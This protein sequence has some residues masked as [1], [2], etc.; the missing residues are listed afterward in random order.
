MRSP[1]PFK[2]KGGH[3]WVYK[4]KWAHT[5]TGKAFL[6]FYFITGGLCGLLW[7]R[8]A[9]RIWKWLG[10]YHITIF[11]MDPWAENWSLD[12]QDGA[13]VHR[14][15]DA[16]YQA[17]APSRQINPNAKAQT[18]SKLST[19]DQ[20]KNAPGA[21]KVSGFG[22]TS[23]KTYMAVTSDRLLIRR[24]NPQGCCGDIHNEWEDVFVQDVVGMEQT[25]TL[26]YPTWY[27]WVWWMP[28]WGLFG[29]HRA[30]LGQKPGCALW[31][32]QFTLGYFGIGWLLDSCTMCCC[33]A[34]LRTKAELRIALRS[35]DADFGVKLRK[36][37]DGDTFRGAI[38]T[39]L[40]RNPRVSPDRAKHE[41]R[42]VQMDCAFE[43]FKRCEKF[44]ENVTAVDRIAV[45][46]TRIT[47]SKRKRAIIPC[48]PCCPICWLP[49]IRCCVPK[50]RTVD[51]E[52]QEVCHGQGTKSTSVFYESNSDI[53]SMLKIWALT[54]L[55]GGHFFKARWNKMALKRVSMWVALIGIVGFWA[56]LELWR[57]MYTSSFDGARRLQQAPPAGV[58]VT[59]PVA[60]NAAL[61]G[62]KTRGL[63]VQGWAR[64]TFAT[65]KTQRRLYVNTGY[66]SCEY[67]DAKV[68]SLSAGVV[69]CKAGTT[70]KSSYNYEEVRCGSAVNDADNCF[71]D[72][73][74]KDTDRSSFDY[75]CCDKACGDGSLKKAECSASN[76]VFTETCTC[77][78]SSWDTDYGKC[79]SFD[80]DKTTTVKNN[81]FVKI[82]ST[83][84]K[85]SGCECSH[86][87]LGDGFCDYDCNNEKC[88]WDY[89][90]CGYNSR[91][92]YTRNNRYAAVIEPAMY[93]AIAIV[94]FWISDLFWLRR[95]LNTTQVELAGATNAFQAQ[96]WNAPWQ[97]Q[98]NNEAEA[99][100]VIQLLHKF[101]HSFKKKQ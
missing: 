4:K 21:R 92:V 88:S 39:E 67:D 68:C 52:K 83:T 70:C 2:K 56:G 76:G 89:G 84:C 18:I 97:C 90:D 16:L 23:G 15:R 64:E 87:E 38:K 86:Y 9:F 99:K 60:S 17:M 19:T 79:N 32:Y 43:C 31:I 93:V 44:T 51:I 14:I 41:Y 12:L 11:T 72:V 6:F 34:K 75:G 7:L 46:V 59:S 61:R 55:C 47:K 36:P 80:M 45:S 5:R 95:L 20:L 37:E 49:C 27:A 30:M 73:V 62:D 48:S 65:Q 91:G 42:V 85:H 35:V 54:G 71:G 40:L 22:F 101:N 13:L 53:D 28:P 26:E 1:S 3:Y 58:N 74:Q 29:C 78:F 98:L 63:D 66:R 100:E 82:G 57:Q 77:A 24:H 94:A 25:Q 69:S 8:D 81:A 10:N 33:I 50:I 96:L